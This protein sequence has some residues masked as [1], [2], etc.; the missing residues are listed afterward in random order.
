[1]RST[2]LITICLTLLPTLA[3][4]APAKNEAGK[5]ALH[6]AGVHSSKTNTCAFQVSQ[7]TDEISVLGGS[8]GERNDI[9]ILALDVHGIAGTRYGLCCDGPLYFYGWTKCSDFEIPTAGWPGCGEGN[10]QTWTSEQ[11]GPFVTIGILDVY[12]YGASQCL[13]VCADPRVGFAEYCD[14]SEPSPLC[15][16]RTHP[17]YFGCT[18]FNGSG[19]GYNPCGTPVSSEATSWGA[20][21]A[22][23][24]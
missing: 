21:K 24:R 20:V 22:L 2:I 9:Y 17:A 10:A 4:G 18:E 11:T 5:W 6:G 15:L 12:V 14:G 16:Q 19:C 23:Y 1:M 13:C 3:K 8:A 7:C